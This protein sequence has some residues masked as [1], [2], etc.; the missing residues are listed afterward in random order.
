MGAPVLGLTVGPLLFNWSSRAFADFYARLADEGPVDRVVI[1]ELVCS[2]RLPFD[3]DEIPTAIERLQRAGKTVVLTSLALPTL[4]RER[5]AARDLVQ[6]GLEVALNDLSLMN[7]VDG[8]AF[9]IGPLVNVYNEATLAFLARRGARGV[10]LPPEAPYASV[11]TMARA[12]AAL[13]V[14]VE[15]WG[16]GLAPLAI[17]ARRYHARMHGLSKD[18]CR[19]VFERDRHGLAVRTLDG[20]DFLAVNGVQTLSCATVNLVGDATKLTQAGVTAL[21]LSPHS[22][23]FVAL[24]KTFRDAL[25][26]ALALKEA[27]AQTRSLAPETTFTHGFL[28]GA[29]GAEPLTAG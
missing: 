23:D 11:R 24:A 20:R 13:G 18:S 1:G 8:A 3:E 5:A 25:D 7:A 26:G 17:S 15:V 22:G 21:R 12:G 16:Y 27:L 29:Y 28:M 9:S 2:K 10:S 4:P 19:F 14:G 6:S